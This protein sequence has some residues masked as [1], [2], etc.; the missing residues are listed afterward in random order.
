MVREGST[1]SVLQQATEQ[2]P[3]PRVSK[4]TFE[5][6][7]NRRGDGCRLVRTRPERGPCYSVTVS[8]KLLT[9][10]TT[11]V[12]SESPIASSEHAAAV[13]SIESTDP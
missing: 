10:L 1:D 9:E 11:C 12:S 2:K 7:R 8:A 4:A 3:N 5:R 13:R 6:E